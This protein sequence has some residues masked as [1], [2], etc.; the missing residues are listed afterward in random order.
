MNVDTWDAEEATWLDPEQELEMIELGDRVGW[1]SVMCLGIYS[2]IGDRERAMTS[3][4]IM[5]VREACEDVGQQVPAAW[6]L[7]E[8]RT[9]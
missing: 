7:P 2:N 5:Q 9:R 1:W 6:L 8:S 4:L 3:T